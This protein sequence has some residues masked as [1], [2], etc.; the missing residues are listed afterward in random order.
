MGGLVTPPEPSKES[1]Y[2]VSGNYYFSLLLKG[3]ELDVCFPLC[4]QSSL[5][6]F[7]LRG[8][9]DERDVE[10]ETWFGYGR[11]DGSGVKVVVPPDRPG[12]LVENGAERFPSSVGAYS[13]VFWEMAHEAFSMSV[14]W[15]D[16]PVYY[17]KLG[18]V[19]PAIA[20]LRYNSDVFVAVGDT[21]ERAVLSTVH[22]SRLGVERVHSESEAWYS[23]FTSLGNGRLISNAMLAVFY[24]NS[25]CMDRGDGC[26]MA[27]KSPKYYVA[28]GFWSRDFVFWTLPLLE[29]VAPERVRELLQLLL[30]K[31]FGG[32]GV[33]A[34]YLDGRVLYD[35][36]ELDELAATILSVSKALDYGVIDV[37]DARTY[38]DSI[39]KDLSIRK[40]EGHHIY[41]TELNSSDDPAVYPYVTYD[42]VVLWYSLV[43]LAGSMGKEGRRI[44]DLASALRE[45]VLENMVI[46]DEERFCYS[47]DLKGNYESYDDPTGS[48]LLLPYF[49]FIEE[50]SQLYRNTVD[51]IKSKRNPYLVSGR[52]TGAGNRHVGHP[53]VH[54]YSSLLLSGDPEGLVLTEMELDRGLACETIDEN[55]GRCLT[56]I[57]F[58]GSSGLMVYSILRYLEG[59]RGRRGRL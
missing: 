57:H 21:P 1:G 12:F 2:Y 34:L 11:K 56:G 5:F 45:D 19:Y 7:R 53:W 6:C 14:S 9:L 27:S 22:L 48:L 59:S 36:F 44:M 4:S 50:D 41:S 47:T 40:A 52:Y 24:S 35:G 49:G 23:R 29:R 20:F 51:W 18:S 42:N 13:K 26:I 55:T 31:Y 10:G 16:R 43:K 25:K 8:F 32:R 17:C 33:H 39:L 58:P 54:Y 28:G 37:G 46:R 38:L 15:T 30:T 3:E